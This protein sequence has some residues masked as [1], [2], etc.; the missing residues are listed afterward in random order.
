ML[1]RLRVI[2]VLVGG[3][4]QITFLKI[5]LNDDKKKVFKLEY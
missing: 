2:A 5:N 1:L 4:Y 3:K